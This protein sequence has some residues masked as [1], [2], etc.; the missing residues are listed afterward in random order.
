MHRA[1]Q[2]RGLQ[3]LR[4]GGGVGVQVRQP[5]RHRARLSTRSLAP[6]LPP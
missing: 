1:L 5:W 2:T 4:A 6:R 3:L